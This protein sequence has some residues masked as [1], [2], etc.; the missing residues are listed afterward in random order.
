MMNEKGEQQHHIDIIL[1]SERYRSVLEICKRYKARQG[2]EITP[3]EYIL[4]LIDTAI[5][6]ESK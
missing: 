6:K 3:K 2:K 5:G 1:D 4:I